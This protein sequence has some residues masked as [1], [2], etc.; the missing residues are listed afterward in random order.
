MESC[1]STAL[2]ESVLSS[3]SVLIT[4][5][6]D[7]LTYH[8]SP[9]G[10]TSQVKGVIKIGDSSDVKAV[11]ELA[12]KCSGSNEAFVIYPISTGNNWGYGSSVPPNDERAQYLLDLSQLN[13][14]LYFNEKTGLC[15][16]QPGVTQ[17]ILYDFLKEKASDYMVP[18]T[19]AG[20]TC[21]VLANA[22]ER[23]YGITP[24]ADHFSA[25]TSIK[26][27]LPTGEY[28]Q[29]SVA[30][31]DMTSE[32]L[33]D[34]SF[35]WKHGPYLD[36]IFTQSANLVVTEATI[37]L[38]KAGDGFTS[39]YM[40]FFDQSSFTTAYEVVSEIFDKVGRNVGS[41]NLMDKRRVSAMMAD[42]P[43]G[44][45]SHQIM[46][47]QQVEKISKQ[48]EIPEWTVIGTVYGA[49]N[50]AKAVKAEIKKIAKNRASRLFFSNDLL[51]EF[52]KLVTKLAPKSLL[53]APRHQLA[54]LEEGMAIMK[55]IPNQVALPL[56]YWRN[57]AT[58]PNKT[59][60][61]N[62]ARDGCGLLWYAPLI[63]TKPAS[64]L[65]FIAMVRETC[66]QFNIEPMITFT[67]FNLYCT[68]STIPIV[69]D[70][71]NEKAKEDAKACLASLY[72]QGLKL[73]FVPYRLNIE[74]QENLDTSKAFW[75][76]SNKI[77]HAL[78]PNN[79]LGPG[80]YAKGR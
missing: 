57:S 22:L 65:S 1:M 35:K 54:T 34:K 30:D 19:G 39:F 43:N 27:F 6:D 3:K 75:S 23:G 61:L 53:Q 18:V 62:P 68:D 11:I 38:E 12:N 67:N 66:Q 69:F 9:E 76:T 37:S 55:G 31:M 47:D 8:Q 7:I 13:E 44:P 28:Y 59:N 15:T 33:A 60:Q 26:G 70:I 71:N 24:V 2:I 63:P 58:T 5:T 78:D 74:Q 20:P 64:M 50:V 21:S 36:G 14:I 73:G 48:Q 80:R 10:F 42:N 49:K 56:A 32:Q 4:H 45:G 77:A 79:I 41:M 40:Q 17:K 46:T 51:I 72:E 25:V 29:S 16:V 52:G